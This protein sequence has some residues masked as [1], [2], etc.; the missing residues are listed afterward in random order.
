MEK[1]HI[2]LKDYA[3][4]YLDINDAGFACCIWHSEKTPSMK[5]YDHKLHCFGCNRS[6]DIYD[7]LQAI[8]RCDFPTAKKML[9]D[10]FGAT[11]TK[12]TKAYKKMAEK[13]TQEKAERTR[14]FRAWVRTKRMIENCPPIYIDD[15]MV[16]S[17]S[18][19]VAVNQVD[20]LE[21]EMGV[22]N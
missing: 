12:Q 10:E 5:V 15:A 2:N 4:N 21:W 11:P 22:I 17:D 16:I 6:G 18:W 8:H 14:V 7:L 9:D 13:R 1:Q 3:Q 19:V 20:R